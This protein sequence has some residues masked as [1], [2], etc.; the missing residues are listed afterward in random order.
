MNLEIG[1]KVPDF[2]LLDQDKKVY[3][4][5]VLAEHSREVLEDLKSILK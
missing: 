4:K 3:E 5:V 1:N 2:T